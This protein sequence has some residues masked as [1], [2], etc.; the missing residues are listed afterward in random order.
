M[1]TPDSEH[2]SDVSSS[3]PTAGAN[4]LRVPSN[5]D[6]LERK[7]AAK[8]TPQQ[9]EAQ[10]RLETQQHLDAKQARLLAYAASLDAAL[11]KRPSGEVA[12]RL[13][14]QLQD[15]RRQLNASRPHMVPPPPAT[16]STA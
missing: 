3:P 10:Q 16:S 5:V 9:I 6:H 8:R 1:P 4:T 11:A 15:V 13:V 2:H 14:R 12:T 7:R